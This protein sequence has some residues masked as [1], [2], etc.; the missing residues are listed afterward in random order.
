MASGTE[1]RIR[2]N[3]ATVKIGSEWWAL[4]FVR[5]HYDATAIRSRRSTNNH[6]EETVTIDRDTYEILIATYKAREAESQAHRAWDEV[7]KLTP[8]EIE[9]LDQ[10]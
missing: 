5:F 9:A 8:S 7:P 3:G 6:D 2:V 1:S 4:E 10:A